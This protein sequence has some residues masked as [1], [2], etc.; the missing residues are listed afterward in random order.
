[1]RPPHS[2]SGNTLGQLIP[3]SPQSH[4]ELRW[5]RPSNFRFATGDH[6]MP[7]GLREVGKAAMGMPMGFIKL[8]EKF[9]LVAILGLRNGESLVVQESGKW[10]AAHLPDAYQ[11][12]PFKMARIDAGR[13]QVCTDEDSEFVGKAA[14]I[15]PDAKGWRVFFDEEDQLAPAVGELVNKM[16][17]HASDLV[18]AERAMEK[19][20]GMELIREWEITAGDEEKPVQVKG[21]H[22]IDQERLAGLEGEAM[23]AL[24]DCGALYLA[25]AQ[26]LSGHHMPS[27]LRLAQLRWKEPE[28]EELDFDQVSDSGSISFDNL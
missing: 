23:V 9:L 18:L 15:S 6:L 26:I 13:Y 14:D 16:Q 17:Q 12:F 1:M 19:L 24:R 5:R 21:L 11:G 8:E 22:N 4:R 20:A 2:G 10:L 25:Y 3:I 27:L 28:T 7:L